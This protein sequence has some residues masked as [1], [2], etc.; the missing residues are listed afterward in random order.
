M[1]S[2]PDLR[3][4][5]TTDVVII[6]AGPVG[7][8][9]VFACGMLG[10]S[11]HVFD[12]L[13]EIGGQCTALYPEKPI[14]DIPGFPM[15]PAGELIS[16][17]EAQAAPFHPTYHLGSPL[18]T[19]FHD[20]DRGLFTLE[21]GSGT[22]VNARAVIIA[23]GAGAFGPNRPP[24]NDLDLFE[25]KSVFYAVRDSA[26]FQDKTL[27]IAGGG[28]S[29]VDWANMLAPR[30]HHIY[31]VHRR[32]QFR[33]APA[34]LNTLESHISAGRVEKITP[35]Q[36][37]SLA[38]NPETGIITHVGVTDMDDR[39]RD[40]PANALLC[41][42]GLSSNLGILAGLGLSMQGAHL[43]IDPT[44]GATDQPGLYAA[45]DIATY[46]HK[47]KLIMTG[48]AEISQT[49]QAIYGA[50]Y[51]DRPLHHVHSTTKGIPQKG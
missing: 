4:A 38:G 21:N 26:R 49:A 32:D 23:A 10:L 36:L 43:V 14:Y 18:Q 13:P 24:I 39:P 11:T 35:Y 25:G 42:Y 12:A 2:S 6:G 34:S 40:L 50:L 29:A 19:L 33:A 46:P 51:P 27:V 7:L 22:R 20:P 41:F 9:G 15:I 28:D 47:Q 17:L 31:L 5:L 1:L 30:A 48:F 3:T 45:G 44:T 37:T 8:F 16:G